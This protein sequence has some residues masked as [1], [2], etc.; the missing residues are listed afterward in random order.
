MNRVMGK[1][2]L[3][4]TV[5]VLILTTAAFATSVSMTLTSAGSNTLGGVYV[6]PYTAT[7]NG[8]STSV[9]CD[10]FLDDS[11]VGESWQA[12]VN[13]FS[14]LSFAKWASSFPST[15]V[16]LYEQAAWLTLQ[17]L[18]PKNA[19]Q[20]GALQ[21]AVWAIFDPA[22]LNN[23]S[24]AN[25]ANAQAWLASAAAQTLT[26]N[27]FSNFVVYTAIPGTATCPGFT[28]RTPPQEFLSISVPEGG[29]L[30]AYLLLAGAVSFG[31]MF[32][33]SRFG[34]KAGTT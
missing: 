15:Y 34:T 16:T 4:A 5:A 3:L 28:C 9:V 10:D 17:M 26:I 32:Y 18:D 14:T 2:W 33:Q 23:L 1:C 30:L 22:A 7:V 19:S 20:I 31:A 6:G 24:G 8:V 21:Y 27:Q 11:F 25:L 29:S 12:N 13:S